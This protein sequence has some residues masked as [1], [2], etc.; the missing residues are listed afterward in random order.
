[1]RTDRPPTRPRAPRPRRSALAALTAV[2]VMAT[3]CGD[4]SEAN[5]RD[6]DAA[7]AAIDRILDAVDIPRST[8]DVG[9][10]IT[11]ATG[12]LGLPSDRV[13]TTVSYSSRVTDAPFDP[14]AVDVYSV[15]VEEFDDPE[16][17]TDD[18]DRM[19]NDR[20]AVRFLEFSTLVDERRIFLSVYVDRQRSLEI[21]AET[22][23]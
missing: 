13:F 16:P 7:N 22:G 11:D 2:V 10:R 8:D 20:S 3:G 5:R 21:V 1:M 6:L 19:L 14:D 17:R 12:P 18:P 15:V 9:I 4:S 23:P